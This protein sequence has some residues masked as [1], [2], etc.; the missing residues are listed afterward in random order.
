MRSVGTVFDFADISAVKNSKISN[1]S[2]R[3]WNS[4][5]P[6]TKKIGNNTYEVKATETINLPT[7]PQTYV[8][9]LGNGFNQTKPTTISTPKEVEQ[10]SM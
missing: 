5:S 10:S 8:Q 4:L 3:N 1:S 7:I 9:R 6:N 2:R